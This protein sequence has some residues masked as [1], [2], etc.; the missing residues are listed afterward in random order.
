MG[1]N[2]GQTIFLSVIGVAT[3]LVAIIGATFAYFTTTMTGDPADVSATTARVGTVEFEAEGIST[4][5]ATVGGN[6]KVFPGWSSGAKTVTVTSGDTDI[7]IKYTC[8]LNV[9]TN[10]AS[11]DAFK[12]K[13]TAGTGT[14]S[15]VNAEYATETSIASSSSTMKLASGTITGT[16]TTRTFT[17]EISFPETYAD[18]KDDMEKNLT[19]TVSC[20]IDGTTLYY[21]N[22]H[23]EG[24]GTKPT[25][26][27][28]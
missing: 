16:G 8:N 7:D 5:D 28:A 20:G 6:N 18:Q 11:A 25:Q 21:T 2:R 10:E 27:E 19:A 4:A 3:L 17:Y 1:D 22:E 12:L 9:T 24:T 23:P 13:V 26:P 14:S 15:E